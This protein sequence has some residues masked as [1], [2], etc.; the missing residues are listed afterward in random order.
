LGKLDLLPA[1][2]ISPVSGA[3]AKKHDL[4]PPGAKRRIVA[5]P[6]NPKK[7]GSRN[8]RC[9]TKN[10]RARSG[11]R[12][13]DHRALFAVGWPAVFCGSG[14]VGAKSA[15]FGDGLA[16]SVPHLDAGGDR[17]EDPRWEHSLL[18]QCRTAM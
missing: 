13:P 18:L 9:R 15:P 3:I 8:R 16:V 17:L 5:A 6:Q 14:T 11:G 12:P 1:S 2:A 7:A 10:R 4:G